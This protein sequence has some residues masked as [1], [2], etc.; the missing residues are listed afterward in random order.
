MPHLQEIYN[1]ACGMQPIC[2]IMVP[3]LNSQ[4]IIAKDGNLVGILDWEYWTFS[5][6]VGI[7]CY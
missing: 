1:R 3:F 7:S 2:R 4:N 5:G 6:M